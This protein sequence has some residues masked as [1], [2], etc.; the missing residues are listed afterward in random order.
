MEK[1]SR[2]SIDIFFVIILFSLYTFCALF[3]TV[4]GAD[5]YRANVEDSQTNY[6]TRTS[7]LYLNEKIRQNETANAVLVDSYDGMDALVLS[8]TVNDY[9]IKTWLYIENDYLCEATLSENVTL[10]PNIGQKIMPMYEIDFNLN[11]DGLLEITVLD[12][13]NVTHSTSIFLECAKTE[14]GA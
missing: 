1:K 2:H 6:N 9:N 14:V 3:L 7:V 5:V 8:Q 11:D 10:I 4:I 12:I 13:D